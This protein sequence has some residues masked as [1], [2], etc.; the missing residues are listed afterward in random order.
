MKRYIVFMLQWI[1]WSGYTLAEWLSRH[2]KWLFKAIMFAL[3]FQLAVLIAQK[4]LK[5]KLQ[6][7]AV[8]MLSLAAYLIAQQLLLYIMPISRL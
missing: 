4:V 2:D 1:V 7:G 3:F 8:T 6:T 5:T